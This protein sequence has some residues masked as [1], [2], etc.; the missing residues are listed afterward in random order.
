MT[1]RPIIGIPSW[2]T[3][4]LAAVAAAAFPLLEALANF[5][6]TVLEDPQT[7]LIGLGVGVIRGFAG[8]LLYALWGPRS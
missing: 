5:D 7:W 3:V 6:P 2:R 8:S 1:D 4:L